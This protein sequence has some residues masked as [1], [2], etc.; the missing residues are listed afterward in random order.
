VTDAINRRHGAFQM[1]DPVTVSMRGHFCV[2]FNR[3]ADAPLVWSICPSPK[4][5]TGRWP[6]WELE[7]CD[8]VFE[9]CQVRTCYEPREQ[10]DEETGLPSAYLTVSG[11]M[12]IKN[13]SAVFSPYQD[14][15]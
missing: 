14:T 2:Y 5:G 15:E 3:H 10:P 6:A 12:A 11:V 1:L 8:V 9:G 7:V 13:G 4:V